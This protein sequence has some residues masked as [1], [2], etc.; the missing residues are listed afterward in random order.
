MR[1]GFFKLGGSSRGGEEKF[2]SRFVENGGRTKPDSASENVVVRRGERE[3]ENRGRRKRE[4]KKL[5]W[6]LKF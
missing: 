3:R 4:K 2:A 1:P 6:V 5:T